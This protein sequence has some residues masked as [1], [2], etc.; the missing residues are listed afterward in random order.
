MS[1]KTTVTG[2]LTVVPTVAFAGAVIRISPVWL[3]VVADHPCCEPLGP[4][5]FVPAGNSP[6]GFSVTDSPACTGVRAYSIL[7]VSFCGLEGFVEVVGVVSLVDASSVVR[8]ADS[9][10]VV[11]ALV[12]G[13]ALVVDVA[14]VVVSGVVDFSVV[15]GADVV[16]SVVLSEVVGVVVD[17]SVVRGADSSEVGVDSLVEVVGVVV[18]FAFTVTWN[19]VSCLEPSR[20]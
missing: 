9:F 7:V 10:V 19:F 17:G 6:F 12:V 15:R 4:L 1:G 14:G 11:V 2:K 3:F 20:K 8:G 16:G 13:V 5:N 18:S